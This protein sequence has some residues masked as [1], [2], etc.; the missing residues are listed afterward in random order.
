MVW[1]QR[2]G[3][4]LFPRIFFFFFESLVFQPVHAHSGP[5]KETKGSQGQARLENEGRVI[6]QLCR[7]AAVERECW[8]RLSCNTDAHAHRH[9]CRVMC[10]QKHIVHSATRK[11]SLWHLV[12]VSGG[13]YLPTGTITEPFGGVASKGTQLVPFTQM[14]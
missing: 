14:T 13:K 6:D 2:G 7:A 9:R 12:R 5:W 4:L 8:G 11:E 3:I 1:R 10:T